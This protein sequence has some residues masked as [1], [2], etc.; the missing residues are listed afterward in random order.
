MSEKQSIPELLC[1]A[2]CE[3]SLCAALEG[4]ADAVYLGGAS[5]N[6]RIHAGNFTSDELQRAVRRAHAY[7]TKVY[8]TLNTLVSDRELPAYVQAAEEAAR[9]G[10]DALI[11]A[12]IGGAALLRR[13][14]PHMELHA[15]TQMSGH[16]SDMAKELQAL[17]FSRMVAARE[18][19]HGDLLRLTA[20]SPI[21]TELFVHGALCVSHSGQCLF[22][23]VVGGRSGNRG[24]CAQPCRLPYSCRSCQANAQSRGAHG[25]QKARNGGQVREDYPLSLKDLSLA[26]HLPALLEAGVHSFKIEGRMKSPEYVLEVTR[27]WRRLIDERRA[28]TPEELRR[29]ADAFSRGGFTDGYFT[30]R[31]DRSMRGV[32]SDADKRSSREAEPFGGLTR[33]VPIALE[34]EI[35]AGAPA[36]LTLTDAHHT[37]V[38][39]GAVAEPARTAPLTEE[40]VTRSLCRL[41]GTPYRAERVQ[42]RLDDGVM[43]PVSALNELRRRAVE[44]LERASAPAEQEILAPAYAAPAQ[45]RE[46]T[47]SARFYR[48]EQITQ[49][50]VSYFEK[51]FLPFDRF[52][53]PANGVILPPVIF[54]RAR[55]TVRQALLRAAEN[56][57]TYALISNLGQLSLAREAGLIPVGDLRLNICNRESVAQYEALGVRE[58][59]LSPELTLPQMRDAGGNTAATVYGRL[60]LMLLEKCVSRELA[61]CRTCEAGRVTL[62]DR[63]GIAFPILREWEHRNV[64]YN[65]LP[66]GMSDKQERLVQ[67]GLCNRHF[68]FSVESPHEV[69]AVIR[70]YQNGDALPFSVRRING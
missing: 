31:I 22:S 52:R 61:D 13:V 56:G 11:L 48:A 53:S 66:L 69:D 32:R 35:R 65:S 12:D 39:E 8:L 7:G 37:A 42:I 63:K 36:K 62:T 47:R 70:A 26:A 40:A 19:S 33:Q 15:S 18:I 55:E 51:R 4:G 64:V 5:M 24:E 30:E 54:D 57:A 38:A 2:G 34:A 67:A 9:A 60:P 50:A 20:A 14:L 23:S 59:I 58:C 44:A 6:A 49:A 41:G 16:N 45:E 25:K 43:L 1:P 3:E 27:T 28:A 10:V 29:M 21:E 46:N 68:L 17:G